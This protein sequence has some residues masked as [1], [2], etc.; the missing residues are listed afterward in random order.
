MREDTQLVL[1][2]LLGQEV[3]DALREDSEARLSCSCS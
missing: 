3:A 1:E 2:D